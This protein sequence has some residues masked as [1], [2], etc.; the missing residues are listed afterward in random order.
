M[1][2]RSYTHFD[3]FCKVILWLRQNGRWLTKKWFRPFLRHKK[4]K[5][6]KTPTDFSST[7]SCTKFSHHSWQSRPRLPLFD[8]RQE[9]AHHLWDEYCNHSQKHAV[10]NNTQ[11]T[12]TNKRKNLVVFPQTQCTTQRTHNAHPYFWWV[13]LSD[14]VQWKF[15]CAHGTGGGGA[16]K[17]SI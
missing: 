11:P 14:Y 12:P 13:H 16:K 10:A 3:F 6:S 15:S 4:N 1:H 17:V 2:A 7:V 9:V 5:T 8:F